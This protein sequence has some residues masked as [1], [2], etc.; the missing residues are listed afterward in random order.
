MD[1]LGFL[2]KSHHLLP[3][4]S[5]VMVNSLVLKTLVNLSHHKKGSSF[6]AQREYVHIFL[7]HQ[8]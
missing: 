1:H 8:R 3:R 5:F 6:S 4:A 7:S 2:Q